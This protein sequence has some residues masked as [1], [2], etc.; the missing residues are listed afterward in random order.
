MKFD[1]IRH[2]IKKLWFYI[3]AFYLGDEELIL[4]VLIFIV[5]LVLFLYFTKV[6]LNT[7]DRV[8]RLICCTAMTYEIYLMIRFFKGLKLKPRKR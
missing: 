3:R 5:D 8:T 7:T 2:N 6:G 4:D 1:I